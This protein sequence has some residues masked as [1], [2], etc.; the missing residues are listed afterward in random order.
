M[1][2]LVPLAFVRGARVRCRTRSTS[3]GGSVVRGD[4]LRGD[5][6]RPQSSRDVRTPPCGRP[7]LAVLGGRRSRRQWAMR[8]R[9]MVAGSIRSPR[10][11]PVLTP[12]GPVGRSACWECWNKA[13]EEAKP[14]KGTRFHDLRHFYASTLIAANVGPKAQRNRHGTARQDKSSTPGQ[15]DEAR[16]AGPVGRD[17]GRC[18][19][20]LRLITRS[21]L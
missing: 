3:G 14:A 9:G 13:V 10:M 19:R 12:V 18:D 17:L 4:L 21:W 1:I 8:R 20:D 6:H 15:R 5:R 11:A 2:T 7:R 16:R